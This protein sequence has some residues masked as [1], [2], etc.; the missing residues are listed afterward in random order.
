MSDFKLANILV[1]VSIVIFGIT[2]FTPIGNNLRILFLI[3]IVLN[4]VGCYFYTKAKGLHPVLSLLGL[5]GYIG[6][7]IIYILP[8][9]N[10]PAK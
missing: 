7:I 10:I 9:K 4:F 8:A 1:T 3:P 6:T 2:A 5:I